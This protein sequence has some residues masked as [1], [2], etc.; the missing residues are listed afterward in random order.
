MHFVSKNGVF[1]K[2]GCKWLIDR[3]KKNAF[4]KQK[5]HFLSAIFFVAYS[6]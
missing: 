3:G 4:C 6:Q 1:E 5:W 2:W